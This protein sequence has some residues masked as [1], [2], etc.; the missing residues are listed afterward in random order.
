MKLKPFFTSSSL[1]VIFLLLCVLLLARTAYASEDIAVKIHF[2]YGNGC[3]HCV[4]EE[5]FLFSLENIYKDNIEVKYYEVWNNVA[6]ADLLAKVSAD[7][8]K[9]YSGVPVT[10]IGKTYISGYLNDQT[11]GAEIKNAIDT[12]FTDSGSENC[13]DVVRPLIVYPIPPKPPILSPETKNINLPLLGNINPQLVSLP[14][15]TAVIGVLD[16]FNPC[17]MWTLLFLISILLGMKSKK[18]RWVLGIAFI[19]ASGFV[20]FLFMSAWLNLFLVLGFVKWIRT[21]IGVFAIIFGVYHIRKFYKDKDGGCDTAKDEK[22]QKV[23]ENIKKITENKK[24]VLALAGIILLAM[25]VNLVELV[26]SAGF[27]AIYTG[28]LA[29]NSLPKIT[30]YLYILLYIVFFMLDDIIVF[31]VAMLT[32]EAVGIQSKYARISSFVGGILLAIIGILLILK[33]GVL[34]LNF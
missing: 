11:T 3:P 8:K 20:Y 2:F 15:V 28:I 25:V 24:F 16:G 29:L 10:V 4:A 18:R 19:L 14:L 32:L 34:M 31:S 9:P 30:Y 27:P 5:N 26:C 17:A 12:C 7:L 13:T 23:F 22:R 6:N 21:I 1:G 33:P